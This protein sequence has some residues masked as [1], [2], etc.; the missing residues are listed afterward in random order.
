MKT[1][2][3]TVTDTR[4]SRGRAES[5]AQRSEEKTQ[6]ERNQTYGEDRDRQR[7]RETANGDGG[8]GSGAGAAEGR[9]VAWEA[10]RDSGWGHWPKGNTENQIEEDKDMWGQ[11]PRQKGTE[12]QSTEGLGDR[13]HCPI[14]LLC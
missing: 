13:D 7:Q 10:V 6:A 9:A 2:P 11:R 12:S 8:G 3:L 1:D 14:T 4:Q 5:P